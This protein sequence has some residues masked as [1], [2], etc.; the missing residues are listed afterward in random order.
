MDAAAVVPALSVGLATD[1]TSAIR[2][3][4]KMAGGKGYA[5]FKTLATANAA[6]ASGLEVEQEK[7]ARSMEQAIAGYGF[8]YEQAQL[9]YENELA[10]RDLITAIYEIAQLATAVQRADENVRNIIATGNGIQADRETFRRRA[11]AKIQ[12][13][14]TKDITFRTFRNESLEQYRSLFD[15]ASRY[16]YLAAK[17]YDYET[18][19]LG[20]TAGQSVMNAIVASRALGDLTGGVPQ[21]TVSTLGDAGLAGTMA[22]LQADWSVAKPRLGINNPDVNGTLFSLR[23]ELFRLLPETA[24][25]TA[26]QQTLEQH[27]MSNVMADPDV[28]AACRNLKKPDGSAV[29]GIVIPF[30]TT[31]Q[32]G[33]NFF[34]LPLAAGDHAF[35]VSNFATKIYSVGLVMRGYIGMDP[36]TA[37]TPNAGLPNSSGTN[38]LSA[39]PYAYLI[40]TGTDYM[41]APPLGDTGSVRAFAV[42]DQ[43]LP[44]PF[45]LGATSFST[46]QFFNAAGTLSEAPWIL[47]KH[48]AFRPV[49][50]PVF[51]YGSVP[52][53]FTS[54]RLV[55]RS[56]WNSG[57]KIVIPANTLLNTEAEG[58]NRFVASVKDLE[59]FLRTYSHSGN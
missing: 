58:L 23:R 21:A 28:A 12:G 54:S 25:D 20:S 26:W 53:E 9:V 8:S 42:H 56:V 39:T 14:R 6:V 13:Y 4:L 31:V 43:A 34:G 45:N 17:S 27:I 32:A 19:L 57:W 7:A 41:L 33:L 29:P 24:G 37:G 44:L 30:S 35:S 2:S 11:A 16:T 51:F 18:G 36:Y 46:T 40:P 22:R 49:D 55:G 5:A 10:L 1:A 50:H 47:R 15:L 3:A 59:I 52:A 38:A 48:Q